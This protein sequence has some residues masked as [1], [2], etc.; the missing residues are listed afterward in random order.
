MLVSDLSAMANPLGGRIDLTWT[1]PV[2]VSFGGVRVL[3]RQTALPGTGVPAEDQ[4]IANIPAATKGAGAFVTFSDSNLKG[5]TVYYYAVVPYDT[6][7]NPLSPAFASAMATTSYQTANHLYN[8]L[9]SVYRRYDSKL[10]PS[11]PE[12][13]SRDAGK[14]QLQRMF[15]L[16]GPQ[17]DLLRSFASGQANFHNR[18][19]V[20]STLLHLLAEWI[21]WETNQELGLDKQRNEIQYAT[22][23]YRT[24]GIAA[25][26]RGTVNRLVSWDA[27]IKEFV[28]N[29][30]TVTNPEQLTIWERQQIGGVWQDAQRVSF[31]IA[32]EGR[33][34]VLITSDRRQ[35]L[36]HHARQAAP[37]GSAGRNSAPDHFHIW[38]KILERDNW[39]AARHVSFSGNLNKYPTAVEDDL[40]RVWVFW[41]GYQDAGG[42]SI[43]GIR[44][45]LMAAGQPAR[46]A[47]AKIVGAGPFAFDPNDSAFEIKVTTPAFNFT[48]RIILRPDDFDNFALATLKEVVAVLERE[49]PHVHVTINDRGEGVLTT[50][51]AGATVKIEFPASTIGTKLGLTATAVGSD[52]LAAQ[53]IGSLNQPFAISEG[54]A[55]RITVDDRLTRVITFNNV[56]TGGFSAVEVAASINRHL[57]NVAQAAGNKVQLTSPTAGSTSSITVEVFAPLIFSIA[58][59]LQTELDGGTLSQTLKAYFERANVKLST[60]ATLSVQTP[61]VSWLVTDAGRTFQIKREG[62]QL[63]VYNLGLAAPKLGFGV[64]LPSPPAGVAETEPAAMKD[65]AGRIWLFFSSRR[66]GIWKIWYSRFDGTGWGAVKQLTNG[67]ESD[68]EPAVLFVPAA[69]GRMWAFW[70]RKKSNGLWNIF[71]NNITNFDFNSIPSGLWQTPAPELTP[72]PL[73]HDNREP[74][75]IVQTTGA[76]PVELYFSSNQADGWH[77]W[78]RVIT[79]ATQGADEQINLGQFTERA[80]AVLFSNQIK[81][82]FS[83]SNESE[84]YTSAVYPLAQTIDARYSGSTM[85]DTRNRKKISLRKNIQDIQRYT[86]DT[87][88][89]NDRW[90]A[91]DTVGIYLVPDTLDQSL[92]IRRRN[93]IASVLRGFL[94]IQVRTV[95]IIDEVFQENVYTYDIA[96]PD[97]QVLIGERVIETILGEA[98][99]APLSN[100]NRG[101]QDSFVDRLPDTRFIKTFASETKDAL[102]VLNANPPKLDFR[103]FL[104]GVDEG[105]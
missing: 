44:L 20:D 97:Q 54:D 43:P 29:L 40:K 104:P 27:Q 99:W 31:D 91:R 22:H 73:N 38:Y 46:Q 55:M 1:N 64:P 18:R 9:P 26:L 37:L 86:Y 57:P 47:Q 92:I 60:V 51:T 72:A 3:R 90:Y 93:Q 74:A 23:F 21:D 56:P 50:D 33:P 101:P 62:A 8:N 78:S 52:A 36:F 98:L 96:N 7:N 35:W 19:E 76:E 63:N 42:Q 14:G 84:F 49:I 66:T 61:K 59:G 39:L 41:A 4:E 12:L 79:T 13:D 68:R 71:F 83:R 87:V 105:E 75:A 28:H 81:K 2:L 69:G 82:L 11:A 88:K 5:E 24:T 102:T 30:F 16:F 77:V 10:P 85:V 65:A 70:S 94:P 80:P 17:F 45:G 48:R 6:G 58:P 32:Y 100:A 53:M 15:E 103:L 95:F 25:N 89:N 67:P 34:A